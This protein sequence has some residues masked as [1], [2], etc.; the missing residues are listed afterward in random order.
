MFLDEGHKNKDAKELFHPKIAMPFPNL[1]RVSRYQSSKKRECIV[2]HPLLE[3]QQQ[4]VKH[5][6]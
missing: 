1:G 2:E 3:Q 6:E 5:F 4:Q